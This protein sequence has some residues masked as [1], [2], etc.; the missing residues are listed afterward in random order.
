MP[1]LLIGVENQL[2]VADVD[3][4]WFYNISYEVMN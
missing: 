4:K 1:Y 2:H 3:S